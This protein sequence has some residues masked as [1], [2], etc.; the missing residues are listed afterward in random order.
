MTYYC[1]ARVAVG[2]R[3]WEEHGTG[4]LTMA[5]VVRIHATMKTM[6]ADGDVFLSQQKKN[7]NKAKKKARHQGVAKKNWIKERGP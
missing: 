5:V 6:A 4:W 2:T 7:N 3:R 1:G